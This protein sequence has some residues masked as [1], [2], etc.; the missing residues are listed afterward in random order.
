MQALDARGAAP[1]ELAQHD[2]TAARILHHARREIVGA[3][4]DEGADGALLAEL[5]R[6][7][8]LVEAVLQGYHAAVLGD[9]GRQSLDRRRRI[10][11]LGAK[12]DRVELAREI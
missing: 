12:K 6:D 11:R 7:H 9:E 4:I 10:R 5:G 8:L 2:S 3:E 1:I